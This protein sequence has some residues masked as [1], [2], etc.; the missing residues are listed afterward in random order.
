MEMQPSKRMILN[1]GFEESTQ[2]FGHDYKEERGQKVTLPDVARRREGWG[3]GAIDE[4]GVKWRG[5]EAKN[6]SD[7]GLTKLKGCQNLLYV[8]PTKLFEGL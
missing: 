5:D 3:G 4:N 8:S 7:L 6:P 1:A 2:A